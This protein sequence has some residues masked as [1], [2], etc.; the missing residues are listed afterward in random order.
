MGGKGDIQYIPVNS[1]RGYW[2]YTMTGFAVGNATS[3]TPAQFQSIADTGTT[4]MLLPSAVVDAYYAQVSAA[5]SLASEGGFVFPCDSQLPDL[6]VLM[7]TQNG[8]GGATAT[9]PGEF[10]NRSVSATGSGLCFGGIQQGS[11]DLSIWGDVF[12]KSQFVVFDGSDPPRIG[13][14]PQANGVSN[15]T[16]AGG[17]TPMPPNAS[18]TAPASVPTDTS[19][20]GVVPC[21]QDDCGSDQ[22]FTYAHTNPK[23]ER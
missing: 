15:G 5:Q 21:S 14:A 16:A 23:K 11:D 17:N 20:A 4:L 10:M 3:P 22:G 8:G 1:S 13:F 12:L 2:E 7:S 19:A 9:I 6:T 18:S